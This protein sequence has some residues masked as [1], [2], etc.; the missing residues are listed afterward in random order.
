MPAPVLR[1][2]QNDLVRQTSVALRAWKHVIL[3]SPTGSGK[4]VITAH[5]IRTAAERNMSA[6]F[7]VHRKELL[8]QTSDALWL[9]EVSHG[10]IA[11]G[12]TPTM[13]PVQVA[14]VQTLVRRLERFKPPN[15]VIIDEAHHAAAL[16]YRKIMEHCGEDSYVV[17]LTATPRRTDGRGLDDL[18]DGIVHGP[19]VKWLTEQ[20]HL[21]PYRLVAPPS[22]IDLTG[23][24]KRMGDYA[25]G[26]LETAV[27]KQGI[28][29]DAVSHYKSHVKGRSCLVYCVSRNHARH[30]TAAY[31]SA[32]INAA[33]CAADIPKAEREA[34][35][36]SFKAGR[37]AVI[38]S[39]DLFGEGLDVPGL[40]AVQLL[41]PTQSLTLHLQQIGRALRPEKNKEYA[42]ILDH[43]G[44]TW[45]HGLPDDDRE[46]TLEGT[47]GK[48]AAE[49]TGPPI[50]LCPECFV[51]YRATLAACPNC[52]V[53]P[54]QSEAKLPETV[55]GELEEID[56]EVHRRMRRR[57]QGRTEGLEALVMLARE[58]GNKPAW[59]GILHATRTKGDKSECIKEAYRIDRELDKPQKEG[60]GV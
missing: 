10:D 35:V 22:P 53:I 54:E 39:V 37:L 43:V 60:V 45:R 6:V 19:S 21:A 16:S 33:Y 38:V 51:M 31:R 50:R 5:M 14:T 41:R 15:L 34:I 46:W 32:G 30:V 29:G 52:G 44:N 7:L 2:Y 27:D 9:S 11:G 26:E 56:P 4:T 24:S 18:F 28:L 23:V 25:R 40:F 17:G 57:E 36:S 1:D 58:R 42:L 13:Q 49:E 8:E 12:R 59:A 48:G 47:R 3:Q 20:G 55:E